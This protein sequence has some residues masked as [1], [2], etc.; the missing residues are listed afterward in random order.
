PPIAGPAGATVGKQ[1]PSAS[2]AV[3]SV[4]NTTKGRASAADPLQ[5]QRRPFRRRNCLLQLAGPGTW[6]LPAAVDADRLAGDEGGLVRGEEGDH[7]GN[8]VGGAEAADRDRFG[9]LLEADFEI[10]GIFAPVAR[11]R[12][13]G[14][15]G[16]GAG[17]LER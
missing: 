11:V 4:H 9:A 3:G 13:P 10:V 7:R 2:S 5:V 6:R 14:A 15:G 16:S 1:D 12:P 17:G 8:L